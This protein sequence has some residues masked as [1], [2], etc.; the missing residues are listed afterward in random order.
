MVETSVFSANISAKLNDFTLDIWFE[1]FDGVTAIVGPSGAGKTSLMNIIAG[2][3]RHGQNEISLN[4]DRLDHLPPEGRRIGYVFQDA[5]L[6]PHMNVAK[7]IMYGPKGRGVKDPAKFE[8]LTDVF[9]LEPLLTRRPAT[10]SGGE[11][12]RVAL[13]RALMSGPR[14]LL[15]DEPLSGIDPARRDAFFPYLE[16]LQATH[17]IPIFYVTHQMDEVMRLADDIIIMEDGRITLQGALDE[18]CGHDIFTR[19]A[20]GGNPSVI[21]EGTVQRHWDGLSSLEIDGANLLLTREPKRDQLRVRIL[22]RDVAI[23]TN[24]PEGISVL[25]NLECMVEGIKPASDN[26][27]DITLRL[28]GGKTR[29]I[30]RITRHSLDRLHLEQGMP[31][32]ALIKA[33]AVL[34]G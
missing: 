2:L 21:L 24:P 18:V 6:F 4:G 28:T 26:E 5:L 31:V 9:D 34:R 23:A 27:V 1:A 15:L 11:K 33:V 29:I 8:E 13:A 10:L 32:W 16:R 17:N 25:N 3:Q 19:I 12:R 30:S 14:L 22:A 7:N 20:G